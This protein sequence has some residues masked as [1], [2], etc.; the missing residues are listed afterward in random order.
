MFFR[1]SILGLLLSLP[2]SAAQAVQVE[3]SIKPLALIIEPL[4]LE[5]D[6]V[7]VLVRPGASPHDYALKASDLKRINTADLL[8]WTGPELERFL[9]KPL[10]EKPAAQLIELSDLSNMH[11][12]HL[13]TDELEFDHSHDHGHDHGDRDP[14]FWL[15]PHN[16]KLIAE[17]VS[18]HLVSL[19]PSKN[20]AY[21]EKLENFLV[22][23]DKLDQTLSNRLMPYSGVGFVVFHKG[24][25]HFV[26]RYELS[27]LAYITLSPEQKP[28]ARHLYELRKTLAGAA[29]CVFVEGNSNM[30]SAENLANDLSIKTAMLD[31]LGVDSRSYE[32]MMIQM[33]STFS[34]CLSG[35]NELLA[36]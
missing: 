27:Q 9:V 32:E 18:K 3:V 19:S 35:S 15:D 13:D 7:S 21:K 1:I 16:A 26:G 10:R 17:H 6:S 23:L 28:G 2:L 8:V 24:Y 5:G 12:P 25:D 14:H 31:P 4:L 22:V 34:S 33:G 20:N 36:R 11:W 29:N 30:R